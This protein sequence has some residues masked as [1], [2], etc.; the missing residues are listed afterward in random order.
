MFGRF[1]LQHFQPCGGEV[2]GQTAELGIRGPRSAEALLEFTFHGH[3]V[4]P[5][6]DNFG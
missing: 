2:V 5:G 1:K 4:G 3:C 6:S